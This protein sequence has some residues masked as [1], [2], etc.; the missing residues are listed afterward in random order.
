L[1]VVIDECIKQKIYG[2]ANFAT[3][4]NH[5]KEA[6]DFFTAVA[7][8]YK[9]SEYIIYELMNQP[10]SASWSQIK[11]YSMLLIKTIRAIDSKNLILILIPAPQWDQNVLDVAKDPITG[12]N[13][14]AYTLHIYTSTHP[15][16]FQ[17]DTRQ[18][19]KIAI[20]ASENG[21]MN[22]N[23]KD[24]VERTRWNS[25]ISFYEEQ[26]IPWLGYD[27]QDT[28]ETFSIFKKSDIFSDLTEW[29]TLLKQTIIIKY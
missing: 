10:E 23:G 15:K 11:W 22:A 9:D 5:L 6:T 2:I 16:S 14:L 12:Y 17:D 25:W 4:Q 27:T 26:S 21:A 1:Y 29:G 28:A 13:K 3:F 24:A 7:T 8:R 19:K 18:A 20:W